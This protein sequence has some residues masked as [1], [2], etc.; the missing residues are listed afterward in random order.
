MD[1]ER[2]HEGA[3]RFLGAIPANSTPLRITENAHFVREHREVAPDA[4]KLPKVGQPGELQ[5]LPR[6]RR[7]GD[8]F[9]A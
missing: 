6:R 2:G 4:W 5:R 1:T 7:P 9:R 8:F 3:A